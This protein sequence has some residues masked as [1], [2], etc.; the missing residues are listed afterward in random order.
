MILKRIGVIKGAC[1][2]GLYGFACGLILSIILFLFS[3]MVS[4]TSSM[5]LSLFSFVGGITLILLPVIYGVLGFISGLI[6]IPIANLVLLII[7]GVDINLDESNQKK[8]FVQP[9]PQVLNVQTQ[10]PV[11]PKIPSAPKI[12]E[13]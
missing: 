7:G 2:S 12:K 8:D 9:K 1:F 4:S 10:K 5:F 3:S 6:F 13:N 11:Q